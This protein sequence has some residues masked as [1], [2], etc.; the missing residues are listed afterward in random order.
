MKQ[1]CLFLLKNC[2]EVPIKC[3][4]WFLLN[5]KNEYLKNPANL[6]VQSVVVKIVQGHQPHIANHGSLDLT[7]FS[8]RLIS[9]HISELIYSN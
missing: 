8:L 5:S 1:I 4:N 7:V 3:S 9:L 2:G 6:S